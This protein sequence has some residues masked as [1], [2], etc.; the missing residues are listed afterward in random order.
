M[1]DVGVV[2]RQDVDALRRGAGTIFKIE[3]MAGFEETVQF[4]GSNGVFGCAKRFIGA[5]FDFDKD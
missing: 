5:G 1:A 4:P 2:Y 3:V